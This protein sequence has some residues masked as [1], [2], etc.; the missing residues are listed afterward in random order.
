MQREPA[1][2]R[3]LRQGLAH[4]T[5]RQVRSVKGTRS[6]AERWRSPKDGLRKKTVRK[7]TRRT[8]KRHA[9]TTNKEKI[10][11]NKINTKK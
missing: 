1:N 11:I 8:G 7:E 6:E 4:R 3:L 9:R 5:E 10:K 2:R